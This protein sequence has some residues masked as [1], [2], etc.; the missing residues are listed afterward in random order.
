MDQQHRLLFLT[1]RYYDLQSLRFA[2]VWAALLALGAA[3]KWLKISST[4]LGP[5]ADWSV[6][7][8]VLAVEGLWYWM[9]SLY[10]QRRFG[11]LKPDPLRLINQRRRGPLFFLFW[12]SMLAWAVYCGLHQSN[13]FFPYLL[14][15]LMSQPMF[16]AE[17][18]P[19]RRIAYGLGGLLIAAAALA[20][21]FA[22]LD[23]W[24]YFSSLC[25]VML[26]L[27]VADHMLL[28]SLLGPASEEA[29]A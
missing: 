3:V 4:A 14:A 20:N 22:H 17:N 23:G 24:V 28:L 11:W 8:A 26:A 5:A 29:D 7:L 6:C 25:A 1:H 9:A 13:A 10:Y 27:G 12:T 21:R 2:P 15:A 18:P 16:D 19:L